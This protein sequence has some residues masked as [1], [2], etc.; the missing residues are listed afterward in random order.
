MFF[1]FGDI[2]ISS[3]FSKITSK[4]SHIYTRKEIYSKIFTLVWCCIENFI[5]GVAL[6]FTLETQFVTRKKL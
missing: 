4:I 6:M 5:G 2:E 3:T 1:Q